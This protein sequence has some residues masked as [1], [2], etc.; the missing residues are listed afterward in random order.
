[1]RMRAFT[2]AA[3]VLASCGPR[4][5]LRPGDG[6]VGDGATADGRMISCATDSL[7]Q[8]G[9]P[10]D[11]TAAP[12]ACFSADPS[13]RGVGLCKDG[14]Q[15]CPNSEFPTYSECVGEVLPVGENC[16]NGL[17]DNCDGTI[18]CADPTCAT[19]PACDTGCNDGQTRACY[20]GPAGTLGVGTCMAGTQTCANGMWPSNCPGE[21]LPTTE[22][23]SSPADKNCN[24]LPGCFDIFAC[25]TSPAC[26]TQCQTTKAECVCPK[27]EGDVATCPDGMVGITNGTFPGTVECCPCTASDC[28]NPGCCAEPVCAGNAA[29]NGLTCN[30][31]PASCNGQVN[32]DCDDF[33]EDCDEPCCK[34][35]SC[36]P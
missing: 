26:M 22:D 24:Y 34:C 35:T 16:T 27:G 31:L 6:G 1:M 12:R 3:L 18:D 5:G 2:I 36:S 8:Q 23:C 14:T 29:C 4:A 7:D 28:T 17:D 19:D 33:P 25:L 15:T 10:C 20:D 11:P 32:F 9:C 13:T 30:T 21:T